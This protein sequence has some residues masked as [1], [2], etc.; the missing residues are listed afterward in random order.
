MSWTVHAQERPKKDLNTH[1]WLTMRLCASRKCR[2]RQNYQLIAWLSVEDIT[3]HAHRA[4]SK[5]SRHLKKSLS[6]H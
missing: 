2:L 5:E 6:N 4:V 1:R 3:Q